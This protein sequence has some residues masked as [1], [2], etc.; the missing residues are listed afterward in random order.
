MQIFNGREFNFETQGEGPSTVEEFEV[1]FTATGA[2]AV[3]EGMDVQFA[4]RHDH[5]LGRVRAMLTADITG[6]GGN[7]VRVTVDVVL[8]DWSGGDDDRNGDDDIKGTIRYAVI[9][10]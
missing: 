6:G 2:T 1:G 10:V 8:R 5:H 3:L 4:N 9:V 7:F